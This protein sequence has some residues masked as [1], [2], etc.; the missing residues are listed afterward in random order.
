[1][2]I[3][4]RDSNANCI[5]TAGFL[6]HK[7]HKS[8]NHHSIKPRH[9]QQQEQQRRQLPQNKISHQESQQEQ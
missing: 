9:Y 5:A 3:L 6:S 4:I 7:F 2:E 1:M 8:S